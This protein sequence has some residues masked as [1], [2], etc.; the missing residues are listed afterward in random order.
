M[1]VYIEDTLVNQCFNADVFSGFWVSLISFIKLEWLISSERNSCCV[2]EEKRAFGFSLIAL[3]NLVWFTKT[4]CR[5]NIPTVFGFCN[6]CRSNQR[7]WSQKHKQRNI[8]RSW[9]RNISHGLCLVWV[10]DEY[11]GLNMVSLERQQQRFASWCHNCWYWAYFKLMW[12]T[13]W[14]IGPQTTCCL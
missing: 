7:I 13:K 11:E 10:Y 5:W 4:V 14:K 3:R 6:F 2:R 9:L 8:S 1:V 12:K